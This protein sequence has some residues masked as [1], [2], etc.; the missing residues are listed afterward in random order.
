LK[1]SLV[2]LLSGLLAAGAAWAVEPLEFVS[3]EQ[4]E[5]FK[6]LTSELRCVVCQN[7]SLADS[8]APL[9]H[10]LRREVF[11][12]MQAG[13]TDE[14]IK[15]FLTDRYGEFVLYRPPVQGSTLMLWLAPGL[16]LTVGVIVVALNVRRRS[17]LLAQDGD[18]EP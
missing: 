11:E 1:R 8:D 17:M 18:A 15:R 3:V 14:E 12:M 13:H 4:E 7:Q 5:R 2:I 6:Q 16:L 9:A 10:D